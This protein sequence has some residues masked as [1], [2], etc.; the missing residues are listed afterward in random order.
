[1][2]MPFVGLALAVTAAVAPYAKRW[3]VP[4][5]VV[6]LVACAAGTWKRNL[7]W[8]TEESLWRDV[9]EKSPRNGRG[10]MNYGVVL[11]GQGRM[12]EAQTYLERAVPFTPN[13][14]QLATNLGVVYGVQGKTAEAER[15]FRRAIELAPNDPGSYYFYGRW[16][17]Q[18]G[19]KNEAIAMLQVALGKDGDHTEAAQLLAT[20]L[21]ETPEGAVAAARLD[22]ERN[23]SPETYLNLSLAYAQAHDY[24]DSLAAARDALKLRPNYAEAYNDI[25]AIYEELHD[26][27]RAI[28]AAEQALRIQPDFELAR[29]N[30]LYS[31]KQKDVSHPPG[32]RR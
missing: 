19:R 6:L 14:G 15:Q 13:Y 22:V 16:L 27:D 20:L 21:H 31:R 8:H 11:M 26:W 5:A 28:Q 1:M 18:V 24:S 2:F 25:A 23:P 7:V 29:N 17:S 32:N 30:L 9:A 3:Y 10:L 12:A 4:A